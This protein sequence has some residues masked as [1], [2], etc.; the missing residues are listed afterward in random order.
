M[1]IFTLFT[2]ALIVTCASTVIAQTKTEFV[3]PTL[4]NMPCEL[5]LTDRE[6]SPE[7]IAFMDVDALLQSRL[8][9]GKAQ[10]NQTVRTNNPGFRWIQ[11]L[12]Q[13]GA[14]VGVLTD[15]IRNGIQ[16]KP[17]VPPKKQTY[18]ETRRNPALTN[19]LLEIIEKGQTENLLKRWDALAFAF[20]PPNA[21]ISDSAQP[22][23][24]VYPVTPGE[25]GGELAIVRY[26]MLREAQITETRTGRVFGTKQTPEYGEPL[27][28]DAEAAAHY[29]KA[30][31]F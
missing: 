12:D 27:V 8:V 31:L 6:L 5:L 13:Y 2:G 25:S 1:R 28:L 4:D 17:S 14:G 26:R 19:A 23:Y 3:F 21:N 29:L 10:Y 9:Y 24:Y 20:V 16:I 22:I 30:V 7:A 18:L 11:H 15:I